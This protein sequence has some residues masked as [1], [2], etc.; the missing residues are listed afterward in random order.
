MNWYQN[1]YKDRYVKIIGSFLTSHFIEAMGREESIFQMLLRPSYYTALLSGAVIAFL[2]WELISRVNVS[3]DHY[4]DWLERTFPR[5]LMQS[6]FCLFIPATLLYIL[7][8]LQMK[9]LFHQ[10]I[11]QT[12]FLLNEFPAACI[13]ILLVNMYY[14]TYYFYKKASAVQQ[15]SR[16]SAI[17]APSPATSFPSLYSD[18]TNKSKI[19]LVY[20]QSILEIFRL[21]VS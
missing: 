19:I 17:S 2:L 7:T 14:L 6:L 1:P 8:F 18:Q 9:F 11:L 3:L 4:F 15:A 5:I 10:D 13:L 16:I 21:V 12:E 20:R